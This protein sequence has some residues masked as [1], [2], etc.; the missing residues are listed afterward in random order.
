MHRSTLFAWTRAPNNMH[1]TRVTL[2]TQDL[3]GQRRFYTELLGLPFV[4]DAADAF[5]VRAG[6]STLTLRGTDMPQVHYIAFNIPPHQ[7]DTALAE[8]NAIR[9]LLW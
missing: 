6:E 7:F 8:P 4:S 3:A 2:H 9:H 1:I 5:T